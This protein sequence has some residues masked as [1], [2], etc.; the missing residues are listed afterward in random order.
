MDLLLHT[1]AVGIGATA[2]MDAWTWARRWLFAVPAPDYAL[3]G[4]WLGHFRRGVFR[5]DAIA[6][7]TP[8]RHEAVLGWGLHYVT[9]VAFATLPVA[10]AGTGWLAAP[11][12]L[13]ALAAGV[14]TVLAPFLL[15]QPGLGAG[16]FARRT[17]R[18]WHARLHSLGNHAV[19]GLGL[20][21]AAT[22][23]QL[24]R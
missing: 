6:R 20:Y 1:A 18:P 14:A 11:T 22:A 7:A 8:L 13:P 12:L 15:L 9:G 24:T 23:L 19:F 10:V 21:L 2:T 17:P 16:L 5:H 4:R 3:V